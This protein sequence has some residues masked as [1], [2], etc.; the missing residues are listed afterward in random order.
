MEV[1]LH[2]FLT[3]ALDGGEWS[4]LCS[5]RFTPAERIPGTHRIGGWVGPRARA[6]LDAV[7]KREIPNPRRDSNSD[8]YTD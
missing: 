8:R 1:W 6:G 7:A 5:G 3:T 2:A 4:A